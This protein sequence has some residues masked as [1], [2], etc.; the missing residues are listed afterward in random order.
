MPELCTHFT[1]PLGERRGISWECLDY[2]FRIAYMENLC[3]VKCSVL[4][5]SLWSVQNINFHT[6]VTWNNETCPLSEVPDH[7]HLTTPTYLQTILFLVCHGPTILTRPFS[8]P[9]PPTSKQSFF[10]CVMAPQFSHAPFLNHT[11]LPPNNP[12]SCVSWPHNSH[13]PL[14]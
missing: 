10:L 13:T 8:E 6:C 7:T 3:F 4:H 14:F 1:R 5:C 12:F 11:H 9:H 2:M